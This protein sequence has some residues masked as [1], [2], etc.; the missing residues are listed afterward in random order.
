MQPP[1]V[2][3]A[4][5]TQSCSILGRSIIS[6]NL[7]TVRDAVHLCEKSNSPA[8]VLSLDQ[9]KAFDRVNRDYLFAVLEKFGFGHTFL[10]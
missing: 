9:T 5:D 4:Q 8:A 3:V 7:N 10:K 2:C 1:Q 6:D